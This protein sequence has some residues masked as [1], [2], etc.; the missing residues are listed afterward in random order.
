MT[1]LVVLMSG[2]MVMNVV[3]AGPA[4][5]LTISPA[6]KTLTADETVA[7]TATAK[8]ADDVETVVTGS[9]TWSMNDPLGS[10][11]GSDPKIYNAGKVGTWAVQV[12]FES[13]T[14]T[15]SVT[16]T[17]GALASLVINPN[18]DPEFVNRDSTLQFTVAGYDQHN[19]VVTGFTPTWSVIGDMG[20]I[21]QSGL[22][23]AQ[24]IGNGKI[25]AS[26]GTIAAQIPVVVKEPDAE[27][28][29][30][31][32]NANTNTAAS[33]NTNANANQNV[34]GNVNVPANANQNVNTSTATTN[35]TGGE[36]KTLASWVWVLILI[37]FLLGV[38]IL[39]ALVPV[40][41]IWPAV[42]GLGG[43][44]ALVIVQRS[45]GCNLMP[46]WSW[47]LSLGTLGLTVLALRQ[48]PAPKQNP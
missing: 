36:C 3:A 34:N 8:D 15:A 11:T 43:A 13:F 48:L 32:A 16:V 5:S 37:V 4:T 1:G 45:Y 17:P 24:A 18:S 46:W 9:A 7:F 21:N 30:A 25:Q 35:E 6:S 28:A 47:V 39:Y 29:N 12:V 20:L 27:P 10:L 26:V 23:S 38:A 22:F 31:N 41:K 44:I 19:N 2:G 14:E 42:V 40:T 33:A